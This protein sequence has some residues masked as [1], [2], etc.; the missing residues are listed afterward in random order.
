MWGTRLLF[1]VEGEVFGFGVAVAGG[2]AE[3]SVA[4]V[5]GALDGFV[6]FDE[7]FDGEELE[8]GVFRAVG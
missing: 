1:E 6:A 4:D 5:E 3:G 7:V 2:F 8:A